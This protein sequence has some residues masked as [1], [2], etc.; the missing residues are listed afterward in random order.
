[1]NGNYFPPRFT[2]LAPRRE[3]TGFSKIKSSASKTIEGE[4]M[5]ST[6]IKSP[7]TLSAS[8]EIN[9]NDVVWWAW[10]C[11]RVWNRENWVRETSSC[12]SRSCFYTYLDTWVLFY[13]NLSSISY[14]IDIHFIHLLC[15]KISFKKSLVKNF[16]IF[17]S[18]NFIKVSWQ[19]PRI[20]I[21]KK[22]N[23][24]KIALLVKWLV[25]KNETCTWNKRDIYEWQCGINH[26]SVRLRGHRRCS[27]SLRRIPRV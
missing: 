9:S 23:F 20:V 6:T 26:T 10:T 8:N 18:S 15:K 24:R 4:P 11:S 13:N 12:A 7:R 1:M 17:F 25:L 2:V 3:G 19:Q 22:H 5:R 14:F 16:L 21:L 27:L